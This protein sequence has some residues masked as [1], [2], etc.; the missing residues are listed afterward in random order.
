[1]SFYTRRTK[2]WRKACTQLTAICKCCSTSQHQLFLR[3]KQGERDEGRRK[4]VTKV[5]GFRW[6]AKGEGG[7]LDASLFYFPLCATKWKYNEP[8]ATLGYCTTG[9]TCGILTSICWWK[10]AA[11][12]GLLEFCKQTITYKFLVWLTSAAWKLILCV[13][14]PFWKGPVSPWSLRQNVSQNLHFS[15]TFWLTDSMAYGIRRFNTAFTRAL[16]LSLSWAESTQFPAL[17]PISSESIL[18]LSS[19]LRLGLPKNLW[20]R[21]HSYVPPFWLH[22]HP[23][24]IF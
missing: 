24:S 7:G 13:A 14:L 5:W 1:M 21:K 6:E 23:I 20:K 8:A 12:K 16:Q 15:N 9:T 2:S 11:S 4:R 17:M 10:T 3:V 19:H 22:A 18:I